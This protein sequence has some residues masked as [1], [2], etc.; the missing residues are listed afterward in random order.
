MSGLYQKAFFAAKFIKQ[1]QRS[2][3]GN[4][5][6]IKMLPTLCAPVEFCAGY[7][8]SLTFDIAPPVCPDGTKCL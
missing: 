4:Y 3:R 8:K 6:F 7:L 1:L 5:L 2:Q